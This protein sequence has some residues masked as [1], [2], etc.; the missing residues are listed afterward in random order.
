MRT[1]IPTR[2]AVTAVTARAA[3]TPAKAGGHGPAGR[4]R[5]GAWIPAS[6][7]MTER[8]APARM[9]ERAAPAGMTE[10][11]A[12]AGMTERV[13]LA[14]GV[15]PAAV[16]PVIPAAV[17]ARAAVTPAEAG[18]HGSRRAA[19]TGGPDSGFRR[20]DGEGGALPQ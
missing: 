9:T 5:R 4:H 12:P 20:N 19:S 17:T 11:A 3:V 14:D 7:G 16:R 6:A 13:V 18:V 8:A 10:G 15:T 2:A 1:A